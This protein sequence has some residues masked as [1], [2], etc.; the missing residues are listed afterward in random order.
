[1]LLLIGPIVD[2]SL[3]VVKYYLTTLH[4]YFQKLRILL[5]I[6]LASQLQDGYE[7]PL[8]SQP[9]DYSSER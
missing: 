1:V 8:E 4:I 6:P 3:K 7:W 5:E 9:E 2:N